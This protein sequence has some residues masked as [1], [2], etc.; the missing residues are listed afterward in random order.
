VPVDEKVWPKTTAFQKGD[1]KCN[2]KG[3]VGITV[4]RDLIKQ[5]GSCVIDVFFH[6]FEVVHRKGS[7]AFSWEPSLRGLGND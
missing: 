4:G 2:E 5:E 1:V 6:G 7:T 3:D